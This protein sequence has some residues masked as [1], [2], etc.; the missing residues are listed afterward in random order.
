MIRPHLFWFKRD[1]TGSELCVFSLTDAPR[2]E[3]AHLC[4]KGWHFNGFAR[5]CESEAREHLS[6]C[7]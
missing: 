7:L 1:R 2:D 4:P 6:A 3:L 5:I